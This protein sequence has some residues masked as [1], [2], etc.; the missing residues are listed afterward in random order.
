MG[1]SAQSTAKHCG[2]RSGGSRGGCCHDAVFARQMRLHTYYQTA[3]I[4][5]RAPRAGTVHLQICTLERAGANRSLLRTDFVTS[6]MKSYRGTTKERISSNR[7][8]QRMVHRV[9]QLWGDTQKHDTTANTCIKTSLHCIDF[10]WEALSE[11]IPHP[12]K[13]R[14]AW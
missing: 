7:V 4:L 6:L 11:I 8:H 5:S 10:W 2:S 12:S 13:C 1:Y 3:Q 14:K 9:S